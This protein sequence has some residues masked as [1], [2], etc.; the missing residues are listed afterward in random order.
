[1][2]EE[3]T[4]ELSDEEVERLKKALSWNDGQGYDGECPAD[5]CDVIEVDYVNGE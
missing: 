4:V 3:K 2:D 1:M 5:I